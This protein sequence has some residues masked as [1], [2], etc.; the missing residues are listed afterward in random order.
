M[1]STYSSLGRTDETGE[2]KFHGHFSQ[3]NNRSSTHRRRRREGS[4]EKMRGKGFRS[5]EMGNFLLLPPNKHGQLISSFLPVW[6]VVIMF[7]PLCPKNLHFSRVVSWRSG[8]SQQQTRIRRREIVIILIFFEKQA[9]MGTFSLVFFFVLVAG[10]SG[11]ASPEPSVAGHQTNIE[12]GNN[13][14]DFF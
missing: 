14:K 6:L 13:I 2:R 1:C 8:L 5:L 11:R 10:C 7:F 4:K 9:K 12:Y 3:R